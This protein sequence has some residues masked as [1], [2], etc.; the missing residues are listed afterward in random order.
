MKGYILE[1]S[2][3]AHDE[4]FSAKFI[5]YVDDLI[6]TSLNPKDLLEGFDMIVSCLAHHEM[7]LSIKTSFVVTIQKN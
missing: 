4:S 2:V 7:K 3:K 1:S 5:E 6:I